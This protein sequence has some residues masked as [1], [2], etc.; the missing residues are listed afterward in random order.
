M[1]F[2]G[3]KPVG[4]LALAVTSAFHLPTHF[5]EEAD[6]HSRSLGISSEAGGDCDDNRGCDERCG[7]GC[8]RSGP[9]SC[10]GPDASPGSSACNESCDWEQVTG[11]DSCGAE[12]GGLDA[13][14]LAAC[15]QEIPWDQCCSCASGA[16]SAS[17][18]AMR[19]HECPATRSWFILNTQASGM[20]GWAVA[21]I[22]VGV[23]TAVA[24]LQMGGPC[25]LQAKLKRL[26]DRRKRALSSNSNEMS[27]T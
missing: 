22:V 19:P 21:G 25:I 1:F 2:D 14:E 24:F 10:D 3:I 4:V 27:K 23:L 20:S 7:T 16:C 18:T 12:C 9:T 26:Q 11:C 6:R 5:F 17:G 8:D 15:S 13:S